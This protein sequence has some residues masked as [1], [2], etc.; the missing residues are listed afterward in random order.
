MR[1]VS[2]LKDLLLFL[3][4]ETGGLD[5]AQTSLLSLGFA[6][7]DVAAKKTLNKLELFVRH[8]PYQVTAGALNVNKI[9]LVEHHAKAYKPEQCIEMIK[10]FL[11]PYFKETQAVLAGHNVP[12]DIGFT[13][14]MFQ[15]KGHL[16]LYNGLFS[17]RSVDTLTIAQFLKDAGK[18]EVDRC[19]SSHLFRKF[20]I[21]VDGRHTAMGDCLATIDLYDNLLAVAA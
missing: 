14:H 10:E 12:F 16:E 21:E 15:Q 3:D 1:G 18:L 2:M 6:V 20:K 4:T 9:D 19:S 17:H 11:Y 8:D 5:P 7:R 13:K